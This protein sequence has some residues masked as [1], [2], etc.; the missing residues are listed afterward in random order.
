[1]SWLY[2]KKSADGNKRCL[3]LYLRLKGL[4]LH[5]VTVIYKF[6][7]LCETKPLR[8]HWFYNDFYFLFYAGGTFWGQQTFSKSYVQ[9]PYTDQTLNAGDTLEQTAQPGLFQGVRQNNHTH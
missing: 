3:E 8:I 7:I 1:M 4:T 6:L 9:Q 2:S 5:K